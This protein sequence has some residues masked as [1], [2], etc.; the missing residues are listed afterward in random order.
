MEPLSGFERPSQAYCN[1]GQNQT[2][3]RE[4]WLP[5]LSILLLPFRWALTVSLC[6]L[7]FLFVISAL[8]FLFWT[9]SDKSWLSRMQGSV[10]LIFA[11]SWCYDLLSVNLD[12]R[13]FFFLHP[14]VVASVVR[15]I[16]CPL[17]SVLWCLGTHSHCFLLLSASQFKCPS[18]SSSDVSIL[19]YKPVFYF[20]K[21]SFLYLFSGVFQTFSS[22]H[23][24][25]L[26]SVYFYFIYLFAVV[27]A[28]D[29]GKGEF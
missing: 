7:L 23:L 4:Y 12:S 13:A 29:T 14:S 16:I 5:Q 28:S 27:F 6:F 26:V 19:F 21:K 20:S 3:C 9:P 1:V 11:F 25:K 8:L 2:P 15:P 17:I 22:E 18:A 10:V 24:F